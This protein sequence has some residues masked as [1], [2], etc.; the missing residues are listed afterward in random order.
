[1]DGSPWPPAYRAATS[2]PY[3]VHAVRHPASKRNA[4]ARTG[5]FYREPAPNRLSTAPGR[6]NEL[7]DDTRGDR[8]V[9]QVR[10]GQRSAVAGTGAVLGVGFRRPLTCLILAS[11]RPGSTFPARLR[12]APKFISCVL[13]SALT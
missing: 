7:P 4:R 13:S 11:S 12:K 6:S 9:R 1:M 2:G 8:A 5:E 3:T 10:G